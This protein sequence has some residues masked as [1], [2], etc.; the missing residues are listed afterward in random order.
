[1]IA[2]I[3]GKLIL[4]TVSMV[5]I[6]NHGIGY[7]V[8][9]PLSTYYELPDVGS[10]VSLFVYT[11][12]KQ[13]S[14]L[15]VGFCTENEKQLFKLMI[16]VSGIGPRLAVNVLSGINSSELIHAIANN[17][18]NRLLKVPGLGRKMAQR[19]ILELRD[20]VS[21]WTS[22]EQITFINNK[23]DAI[24]QS[25]MEEDAISALINL[26]YKSQAAKDAID[27]V[28]SEGGENKSLDVILKKALKVLAM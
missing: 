15:L 6:D 9:I 1:M 17:D 20:K 4:K 13:D 22:K 2:Q 27:R 24:D 3:R 12:F 28:I 11:F 21:G 25:V 23:K 16:S 5:I 10:E 18:L 19:V 14:I 26:G 8:M 7:E